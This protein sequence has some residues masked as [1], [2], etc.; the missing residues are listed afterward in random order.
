MSQARLADVVEP[1]S[2]N[3]KDLRMNRR[4]LCLV[5]LAMVTLS[6][7]A[8]REYLHVRLNHEVENVFRQDGMLPEYA[9]FYNGPESEPIALLAV[10][11]RY[12]LASEFW[13]PMKDGDARYQGW[14]NLFKR[15]NG[16][17][18]DIAYIRIDYRG[19][20][21]LSETGERIGMAYSRYD[22]IVSWRG[23]GNRLVIPPP[24]PSPSQQPSR[25]QRMW[26]P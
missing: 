6:G 26:G 18:D 12:S 3:L 25:M 1:A 20:E 19:S 8:G 10:D 24:Q 5:V 14:I 17:Y 7:C 21:I 9:Y 4:V 23:E 16:D 2:H 13:T 22:W 11:K 15:I